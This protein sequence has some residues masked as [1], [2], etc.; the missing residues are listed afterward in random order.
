MSS[1]CWLHLTSYLGEEKAKS[2]VFKFTFPQEA[3]S[4]FM[5]LFMPRDDK[6]KKHSERKRTN[7]NS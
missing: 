2:Y 4:Y 7:F 5:K 1:A 3:G 6:N